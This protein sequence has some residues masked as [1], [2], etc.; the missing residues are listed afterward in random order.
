MT[1]RS[2]LSRGTPTATSTPSADC[3]GAY[4]ETLSVVSAS[5]ILKCH[6][7]GPVIENP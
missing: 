3:A 5:E 6:P 4:H 1:A 7:E 2:A